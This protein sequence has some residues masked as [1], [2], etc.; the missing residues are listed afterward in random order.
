MRDQAPVWDRLAKRYIR[1]P[2]ADPET[3]EWKLA[4]TQ[5]Y[6]R[7][8]MDVLE[9]GCGSGN[10]ARRHAPLVKSY[11]AMD[12]SGAMLEGARALGPVPDNMT[13]VQA[14]F[15]TAGVAPESYD[16]VL[17]LSVL[18]LVPDPAATVARIG[19]VLRPGGVFVASTAVLGNLKR[20]RFIAAIGQFFGAIPHLAYLTEDDMRAMMCDAGLEVVLDERPDGHAALVLIARK[21]A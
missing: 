5:G 10:T 21:P 9:I 18:H 6:M 19:R 12:I 7:S 14:D 20:L 3:Y 4:L 13:F 1:A 8:D 2:L 16:M 15:D 17:A 11:T